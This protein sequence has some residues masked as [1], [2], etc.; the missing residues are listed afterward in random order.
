MNTELVKLHRH[1]STCILSLTCLLFLEPSPAVTQENSPSPTEALLASRGLA[2]GL[3]C[4]GDR[5]PERAQ[6][7]LLLDIFENTDKPTWRNEI[8]QFLRDDPTSPC[9][10]SLHGVYA[11]FC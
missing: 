4:L 2:G 9:A 5:E 10:A 6:S 7:Q 1:L 3:V 8:E 11:A